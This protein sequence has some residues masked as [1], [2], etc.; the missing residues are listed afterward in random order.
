MKRKFTMIFILTLITLSNS[1]QA[2]SKNEQIE[3]LKTKVDSLSTLIS[4]ERK[5]NTKKLSNHKIEIEDLNK[6]IRE[7]NKAISANEEKIASLNTELEK[8]NIKISELTSANEALKQTGLTLKNSIDA[9]DLII[10]ELK[11][12]KDET[13]G[14][15]FEGTVEMES[16]Y[17]GVFYLS[18][19]IT[20]G[21]LAGKTEKLFF[22]IGFQ[23]ANTVECKGNA[24][25]EGAGDN[26]G[27]K[28][29]GKII[30]SS[31]EF[32]NYEDGST[33]TKKCY[34]PIEL[35]WI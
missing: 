19:K 34:R 15:Y 26:G 23:D 10:A 22:N 30:E 29:K 11:N 35:N 3:T 20:K 17:D 6:T 16:L 25:F 1:L 27:K 28:V 9:K 33:E 7:K 12:T 5:E 21:E 4:S 13:N 31:G 2:Q 24:V 32:E 14:I 18:V 8:G